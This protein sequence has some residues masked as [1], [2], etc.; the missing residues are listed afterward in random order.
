MNARRYVGRAPDVAARTVG[1]ELMIMSGRDST[2][3][4]LNETAAALW[5]AADGKTTL[6][7]IVHEHICAEFDVEPE[8]ALRDAEELAEELARSGILVLSDSPIA[9][10]T[11]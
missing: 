1:G 11:P 8:E 6:E 9:G 10:T 3:F 5:D 2:L 4:S 7:A